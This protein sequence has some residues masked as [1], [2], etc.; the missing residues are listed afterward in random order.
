VDNAWRFRSFIAK[1]ILFGAFL[2]YNGIRKRR[3]RGNMNYNSIKEGVFLSRP[4]RFIAKVMVGGAE[5]TV[6][7]KNTG[8][9]RELLVPGARVWLSLADNPCRKTKYDLICVEKETERG[10]IL[11]NMDSCVVNDAAHEWLARGELFSP[12]ARI[13]REHTYG[14]SRF[15]FFIEDGDKKTYLEVKGVTLEKD[16]TALFPDAPTLRGVKHIRSLSSLALSGHGAYILF[17]VQFKGAR[18][19]SPNREMHPEFADALLSACRSGVRI[20]CM[21]CAVT[22]SSIDIDSPVSFIL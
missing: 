2:W 10:P 1:N 21:D 12:D 22:P 17:V 5:E 6:H 14:E 15:D 7:V 18:S 19:F 13:R 20:L 11:I 4:N 16:G 8:R 3:F 9:C